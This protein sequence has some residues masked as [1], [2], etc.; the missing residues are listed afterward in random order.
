MCQV[1]LIIV[2]DHT[3]LPYTAVAVILKCGSTTSTKYENYEEW[4]FKINEE[5]CLLKIVS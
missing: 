4:Y 3:A 1:T 2:K 5:L